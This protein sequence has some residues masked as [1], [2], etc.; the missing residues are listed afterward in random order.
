ML[1]Q[2]KIFALTVG[3]LL[4]ILILELI[5]RRKLKEEFSWIWLLSGF[6][7][8]ILVVYYP[9]LLFISNLMGAKIPVTALFLSGFLFLIL[10]TL[11]FSAKLSELSDKLRRLS[12]K[13]SL[14]EKDL[15]D[16]HKK[17]KRLPTDK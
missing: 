2:Q 9:L 14:L 5:R 3:F 6:L 1:F 7:I 17:T 8:F 11:F 12:Q 4:L 13:I 16:R 10:I 15:D